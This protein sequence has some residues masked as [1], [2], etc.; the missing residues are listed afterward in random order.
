MGKQWSFGINGLTS[1]DAR[2]I[3][4][5]VAFPILERENCF[6]YARLFLNFGTISLNVLWA[7]FSF[8]KRMPR[9]FTFPLVHVMLLRGV[10]LRPFQLPTHRPFFFVIYFCLCCLLI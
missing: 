2:N 3:S 10:V 9:F 5:T 4:A 7:G 8:P 1:F 6:Q